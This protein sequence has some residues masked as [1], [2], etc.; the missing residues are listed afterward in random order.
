MNEL[1]IP[2]ALKKSDRF[3]EFLVDAP[4]PLAAAQNQNREGV[5]F[6][7]ECFS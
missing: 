4:A 2:F 7:A 1:K 5:L 3:Q 6:Q